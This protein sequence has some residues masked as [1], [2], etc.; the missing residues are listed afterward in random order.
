[1]QSALHMN[2]FDLGNEKF[3]KPARGHVRVRV[4]VPVRL[5]V[6]PP[7]HTGPSN[8]NSSTSTSTSTNINKRQQH[9]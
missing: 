2:N 4:R 7:S 9:P 8:S 5:P 1:M 6:R 3:E